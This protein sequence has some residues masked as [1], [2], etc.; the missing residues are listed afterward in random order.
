MPSHPNRSGNVNDN[1]MYAVDY[2]VR[3]SRQNSSLVV[4][5]G[6]K[7]KLTLTRSDQRGLSSDAFEQPQKRTTEALWHDVMKRRS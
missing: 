4:I 3:I 1:Q 7:Y 5:H 6:A 2:P